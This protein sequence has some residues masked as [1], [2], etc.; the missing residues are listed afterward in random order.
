MSN[1][2]AVKLNHLLA[3]SLP[4][5]RLVFAICSLGLYP[6]RVSRFHMWVVPSGSIHIICLSVHTPVIA[7][8]PSGPATDKDAPRLLPVLNGLNMGPCSMET[9][10]VIPLCEIRN[11][12][13]LGASHMPE[14]VDAI[15]NKNIKYSIPNANVVHV[16]ITIGD[17]F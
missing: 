10:P 4:F 17:G 14:G 16:I 12:V 9:F 6:M 3:W 15:N 5:A 13:L 7:P 2:S 1:A 11:T 8:S